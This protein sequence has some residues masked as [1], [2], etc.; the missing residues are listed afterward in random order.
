[1]STGVRKWSSRCL[2]RNLMS[3]E[4]LRSLIGMW[5]LIATSATDDNGQAMRQPYG[6][7]PHGVVVFGADG[8][9]IAVLCDARSELPSGVIVRPSYPRADCRPV[10]CAGSVVRLAS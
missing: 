8:R 3:F 9:M 1:M 6:P 2:E 10:A 7:K 4:K 5:R